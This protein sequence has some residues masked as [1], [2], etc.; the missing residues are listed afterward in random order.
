LTKKIITKNC[1]KYGE[2]LESEI[3]DRKKAIGGREIKKRRPG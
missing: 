2:D 3:A 1:K